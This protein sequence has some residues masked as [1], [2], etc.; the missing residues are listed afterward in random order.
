[1]LLLLMTTRDDAVKPVPVNV[2]TPVLNAGSEGGETE[3]NEGTGGVLDT[4]NVL[5]FDVPPAA[6]SLRKAGTKIW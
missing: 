2:R 1:M 6:G 5:T 4:V 3:V